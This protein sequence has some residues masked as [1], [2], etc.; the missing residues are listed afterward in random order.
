MKRKWNLQNTALY[1]FHYLAPLNYVSMMIFLFLNSQINKVENKHGCSVATK[2]LFRIRV[3]IIAPSPFRPFT[4]HC[5]L[6]SNN[7]LCLGQFF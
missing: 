6:L 1:C 4:D 2:V 3:C 7:R 5:F